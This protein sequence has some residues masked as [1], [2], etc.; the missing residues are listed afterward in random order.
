MQ[1]CESGMSMPCY[2]EEARYVGRRSRLLSH[3]LCHGGRDRGDSVDNEERM[4]LRYS[5]ACVQRYSGQVWAGHV[6]SRA[7]MTARGQR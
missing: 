1:E 6:L 2:K 3:P 4:L 7:E 5:G